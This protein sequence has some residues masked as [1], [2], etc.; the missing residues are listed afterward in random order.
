MGDAEQL[1]FERN[2]WAI[3]RCCVKNAGF[4]LPDLG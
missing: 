4:Q 3:S 2:K 1:G